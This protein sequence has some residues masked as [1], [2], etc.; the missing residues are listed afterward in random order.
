MTLTPV[1]TC[2]D[3]RLSLNGVYSGSEGKYYFWGQAVV[4][5]S[6]L[7]QINLANYWLY[8]IL[9]STKMAASDDVTSY[10]IKTCELEYSCMRLLVLLSGGVI[11]SG[12]DWSVGAVSVKPSK[13][14]TTYTQMINGFRDSAM[15][16]LNALQPV[17]VM[18]EYEVP[19]WDTTSTSVM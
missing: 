10:H 2:E 1:V 16:H 11:I 15:A 13:M 12:F 9:G 3:V 4:S 17:A 8:G 7:A 14:Q 19:D 18:A 5:G 6:V